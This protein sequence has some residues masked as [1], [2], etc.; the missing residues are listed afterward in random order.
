MIDSPY[1]LSN[2]KL[3]EVL[4]LTKH[5][6]AIHI[7]EDAI[8]QTANDAM[9]AVWGKDKSVIGKSLADAL[10]E[11]RGQPFIDLFKRVWNEG[12]TI[13]GT[14]TP[15]DLI[16]NG[17][18]QTFYFDFEYR[19]I[20]DEKGNTYAILHMA[21]DITERYM[22]KLREQ[23]LINELSATN[24]ELA[25]S[26]EEIRA[27]NEELASMNEEMAATN[28]ELAAANEELTVTNEELAEAQDAL[29]YTISRLTES[30][31]R[32]Q[33]LVRDATTGIIVLS[34]KDMSVLIVN[35]AYGKLIGRTTDQ[36][37]GKPLFDI[38]PEAEPYFRPIIDNVRITDEP[39]YIYDA[40]YSVNTDDGQITGFLNVV[41]Q[42][43]READNKVTGVMVLCQDVTEQVHARH[44]VEESEKRFRFMLDAIPQQVWTARPDGSLDYVNATTTSDFGEPV[45]VIVEHGWQAFIHPEDL[46]DTLAVW[47]KSL[48]TGC[49]YQIEFRLKF[50]DGEYHW[51]LSRALPLMENGKPK[52]W[53]GTN[54]NI[55]HQKLNEQKKDEF[56]SIASHELKTP[57]TSIKAFNQLMARTADA[58]KLSNFVGKSAEHIVR[59]EKLINDLLDV[60]KI[61][62][63]KMEYNMQLFD[64]KQMLQESVDSVQLTAPTHQIIVQSNADVEYVGDRFRL[65]QV[66]NNFLTN[67]VK[68]SPEGREVVV[69]SRVDMDSL[70]V[71]VQD[72]GIGI[73]QDHLDKLFDRYYRVDNTAMRFEGLGLGLFISSEI[74][75]R[76]NGSFWIESEED[77][78][79]TFYFRLPLK[80]S[81][82]ISPIRQSDTFYQD[83]SITI[84]YNEAHQWLD[85]DWVG[86][87]NLESVQ[88]G[89]MHMLNLLQK[90]K[91]R[92]VV[93]D[94][95]NVLGTWSEAAEWVGQEWFPMAEKAGLRYVAWIF[96]SSAFSQ[97]SA[98]KSI[99][100]M[101][102]N[103]TTQFFIDMHE[104]KE[105]I[106]AQ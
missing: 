39:L 57:L 102:G 62:A 73:A 31:G 78:G 47:Q 49:E 35:D 43:F 55:H 46:P 34:G 93:N 7:S 101:Q 66:V 2:E 28:E 104:A 8:I 45:D 15:A 96:S 14:D 3:L 91:C 76:H 74:L 77:K 81:M 79:S 87:Q 95:R 68:Y 103:V 56:L 80:D 6:T 63:G 84:S 11:L 98:R 86:Y 12:I 13:S 25:A 72:F 105:W 19:A 44:E 97:L 64:F 90:N 27:S 33:N 26:N 38:I 9:L 10:P 36:L 69:N 52:L 23:N 22:S 50:A 89:C 37:M 94:N 42:P 5:P 58:K 100:V 61:N 106:D 18:L 29:Q 88:N 32:F 60:T 24:E 92:K 70:V 75:K 4:S 51:H 17:K 16:V 1:L 71:S 83:N 54:T 59:L 40:P 85:V 67:A 65:E 20:K 48:T 99:N 21:T 53:L 82:K 30:E 41:Y